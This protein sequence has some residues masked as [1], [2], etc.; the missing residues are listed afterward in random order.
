[1]SAEFDD[2]EH[3]NPNPKPEKK[4]RLHFHIKQTLHDEILK[5]AEAEDT[6]VAFVIKHVMQK[7]VRRYKK[8]GIF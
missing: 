1:M 8:T 7:F 2:S 4:V 5:V 3:P 6:S